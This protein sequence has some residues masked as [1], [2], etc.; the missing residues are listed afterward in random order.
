MR[1][2]IARILA[3]IP[4]LLMIAS[5]WNGPTAAAESAGTPPSIRI[6]NLRDG[7]SFA[8]N[9]MKI[10]YDIRSPAGV[11]V[12][13]VEVLVDGR[14]LG[15]PRGVE[16]ADSPSADPLSVA[17]QVVVPL[18]SRDV[19]VSLIARSG[20]LASTPA[21]VKLVW[22]GLRGVGPKLYAVVIGVSQYATRSYTLQYAAKDAADFATALKAQHGGLYADVQVK[23]L[24]DADAT[25][26]N[27][28]S[29]LEWLKRAVTS[30]DLG[31]V[32]VAGHGW[33]DEV[34]NFWFLPVNATPADL[35]L[36]I[37]KDDILRPM[38]L[39]PARRSFS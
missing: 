28:I 23:V 26:R 5:L 34:N 25:R 30:N 16:R 27:I 13:G 17:G 32:Y 21:T 3:A 35:D 24:T 7:D 36:A 10:I 22:T 38:Q 39:W 37:A 8:Q 2:G 12:D 14:S 4:A 29:A 15:R 1:I 9:Q 31:I 11:S 33:T 20:N 6:Y 19:T 18:P